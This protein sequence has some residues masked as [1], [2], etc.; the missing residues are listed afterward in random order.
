MKFNFLSTVL[1]IFALIFILNACSKEGTCTD[2]IQNN[3]EQGIDCCGECE[4]CPSQP[5]CVFS[6]SGSSVSCFDGMQNGDETGVDCGGNIC[7][8]C[9]E[10][11]TTSNPV[12]TLS[13]N[14]EGKLFD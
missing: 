8:P 12:D 14:N 3:G 13:I 5:D 4:P 1:T 10:I 7:P 9:T 11:D 6:T 2:G